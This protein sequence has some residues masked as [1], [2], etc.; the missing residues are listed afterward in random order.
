MVLRLAERLRLASA[1]EGGR[2]AFRIAVADGMQLERYAIET[3]NIRDRFTRRNG[4]P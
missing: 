3:I 4:A 2:V 1:V